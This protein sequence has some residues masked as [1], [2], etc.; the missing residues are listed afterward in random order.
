MEIG[1]NTFMFDMLS[2]YVKQIE[3]EA[4]VV[5]ESVVAKDAK[6]KILKSLLVLFI[7]VSFQKIIF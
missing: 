4:R 5:A 3:R 2:L 6:R 7:F 1:E